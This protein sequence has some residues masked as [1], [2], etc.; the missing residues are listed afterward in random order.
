MRIA[1]P[2]FYENL[3]LLRKKVEAKFAIGATMNHEDPLLLEG[4][5]LLFNWK[6]GLHRDSQDPQ[7]GYAG[8]FAA[9]SFTG[10]DLEL[11]ELKLRI[12]LQPGDLVLIRGRVLKHGI[13]EWDGGQRI[14]IP[15][16][17][18]TDLWTHFGLG[19]LVSVPKLSQVAHI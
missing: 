9:G 11:P 6:S 12:R 15:H 4:R 19:D 8:L 17:T 3:E 10:G 16:F 1:D 13:Q 7:L 18:H 2:A 14:C 5:E